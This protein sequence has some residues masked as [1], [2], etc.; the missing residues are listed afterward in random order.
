VGYVKNLRK[1]I[2]NSTIAGNTTVIPAN[3]LGLN[4]G[5]IKVWQVLLSAA[6]ANVVTVYAGT[7]SSGDPIILT[8]NGASVTLQNTEEPWFT[9]P[10][11]QPLIINTTTT[12]GVNGTF[13]YSLA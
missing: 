1:V 11:G 12:A 6:G 5:T 2:I 7:T 3:Q 10:P 8:G 9:A 4:Y 13:Y